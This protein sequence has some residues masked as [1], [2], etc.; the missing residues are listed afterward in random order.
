MVRGSNLGSGKRFVS[1][2]KNI[3]IGSGTYPPFGSMDTGF[4]PGIKRLGVKLTTHLI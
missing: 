1:S 4:F 3:Q 2:P